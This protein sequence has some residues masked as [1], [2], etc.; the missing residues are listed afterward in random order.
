A[1]GRHPRCQ[2]L[3]V[4]AAK[5]CVVA[6]VFAIAF[7]SIADGLAIA[8][9]TDAGE[10]DATATA[11]ADDATPAAAD[12]TAPSKTAIHLSKLATTGPKPEPT[13]PPK[14]EE[15]TAA[16][17]R[18]VQFL[19]DDERPDGSWGSPENTKGLNIYAPAPGAH[20]AFRT[21]VTSLAIM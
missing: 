9:E 16:L 21:G 19:L 1:R 8:V 10:A 5:L 20:D 17:A 7:H 2:S 14:P 18:G 13:T 11:A 4:N 3:R 6:A 15:I 12:D